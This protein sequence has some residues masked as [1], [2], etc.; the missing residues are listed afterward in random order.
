MSELSSFLSASPGSVP[1]ESAQFDD[2]VHEASVS[3]SSF[4]LEVR[5]MPDPWSGRGVI[6]L[7]S[8]MASGRLIESK[9]LIFCIRSDQYKRR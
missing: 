6:A 9:M 3:V 1:Y 8:G 4:G 2:F 5:R 7:V